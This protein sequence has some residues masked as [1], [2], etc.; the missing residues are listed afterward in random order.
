ME[1][2]SVR[3]GCAGRELAVLHRAQE[4]RERGQR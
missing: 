2:R 1:H 3:L 4:E